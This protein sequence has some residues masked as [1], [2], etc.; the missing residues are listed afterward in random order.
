MDRGFRDATRFLCELMERLGA[1]Q[2]VVA[3]RDGLLVA[4]A[5]ASADELELLAAHAPTGLPRRADCPDGLRSRGF[6]LDGERVYLASVGAE[7]TREA[8]A[9]LSRA[10][11]SSPAG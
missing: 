10:L 5:G 7:P 8:A 2:A 6:E 3:S 4:G 9:E 11:A 1:R